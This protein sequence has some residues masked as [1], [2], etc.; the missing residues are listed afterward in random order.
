MNSGGGRLI[1]TTTSRREETMTEP[2]LR[3]ACAGA[4]L[5]GALLVPALPAA[6]QNPPSSPRAEQPSAASPMEPRIRQLHQ[7][8]HITPAQEADFNAFAEAMRANEETMRSL[9]QQRPPSANT[10]AV[11]NLRFS[12]RLAAAQAEG[13][14]RLIEPFARLYASFSPSQKQLANRIFV[15]RTAA[16]GRG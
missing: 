12:Q 6:A 11:A 8:L 9:V 3:A 5:L 2:T 16:P 4:L 13:L 15:P 7:V 1:A 10:N 14:R